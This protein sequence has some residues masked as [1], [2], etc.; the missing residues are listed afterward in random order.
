MEAAMLF[1]TSALRFRFVVC[2]ATVALVSGLAVGPANAD[3]RGKFRLQQGGAVTLPGQQDRSRHKPSRGQK[4]AQ[5]RATPLQWPMQPAVPANKGQKRERGKDTRYVAP[6][7]QPPQSADHGNSRG[8]DRRYVPPAPPPGQAG[9]DRSR[10]GYSEHRRDGYSEHRR[11][12]Y[13]EHR[14]DGYSE[15]RRHGKDDHRRHGDGD[16]WRHGGG[17]RDYGHKHRHKNTQ[18]HVYRYY[19]YRTS[20]R[21]YYYYYGA[22][23]PYAYPVY[24]L[25]PYHVHTTPG[26]HNHGEQANYCSDGYRQGGVYTGGAYTRGASHQAGGAILGGLVGA[27][28]GSQVG[29]GKGKLVAVGVGTVIGALVGSDVG[30][31]MDER[32]RAYA[33]GS[34]GHAMETSPTCTTITWNNQQTGN[35]G[36]VTPVQTYEPE[37][38]RYCREFQQQVM[39]GGNLQDAYGTAC[40]QPDGS[41]EIVAE[42]P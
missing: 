41:W 26:Y 36:S 15:H 33:T 4:P 6:A 37:P 25:V 10:D 17:D 18:H 12:G 42:Q 27:A 24:Y 40:R 13:N 28:V 32:D 31:A 23:R 38:G 8:H 34:F 20:P 2:A 7:P 30:R 29:N 35:Y 21:H 9:R 14:R 22:P 11:D 39:I 16:H 3:S 1:R 19:Y 5:A